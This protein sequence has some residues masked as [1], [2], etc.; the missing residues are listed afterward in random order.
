MNLR[1][2]KCGRDINYFAPYGRIVWYECGC[3]TNWQQGTEKRPIGII[4]RK[5]WYEQR[6]GGIDM[7]KNK[8]DAAADLAMCQAATP[9]PWE[10]EP[11]ADEDEGLVIWRKDDEHPGRSEGVIVLNPDCHYEEADVTFI[12]DSRAALPHWIERAQAAEV[13]AR[14]LREALEKIDIHIRST[15][16]PVPHI[17]QTLKK[18]LPE[19][20]DWW[21]IGE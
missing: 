3:G 11:E 18:T 1:C 20:K 10:L 21:D 2:S 8:R 5:L 14:R 4:P 12:V 13:E 19:Y 16:D 15:S 7:D 17:I 6:E 9:G